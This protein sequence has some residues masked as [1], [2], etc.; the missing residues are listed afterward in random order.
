VECARVLGERGLRRVHLV[1]AADEIGGCMRWNPRLPGLGEW[2]RV[3]NYRKIQLDKLR[4]VEVL[5]GLELDARGVLDYGAELVVVATGSSWAGDGLNGP[6]QRPVPGADAAL[7]HVL[8]PEQVMLT[9]KPVGDRVVVF[10]TDG[11]FMGVGMAEKLAR[12]GRRVTLVVPFQTIAPYTQ[13]TL[14]SPRLN[15]DLRALGVEILTEHMLVRVAAGEAGAVSIWG[16]D[17]LALP[18]DSVVLTTQRLSDDALHRALDADRDAL[19]AAG[20]EGLYLI[21]DAYAPGLIAEAVFSGH[22]LAREIDSGDPMTPL[23]FIRERRVLG[24]SDADYRLPEPAD[25]TA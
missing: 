16:G 12:E 21:G 24:A 13:F 7:P 10:D 6:T 11:Y 23:P 4:N 9:D 14:E 25:A 3:V 20:I 15:R 8:T 17:A 5:T 18:A 2:G 1:D 22:R 19:A